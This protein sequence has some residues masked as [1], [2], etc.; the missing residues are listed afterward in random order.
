MAW[1]F[2][3]NADT[4]AVNWVEVGLTYGVLAAVI[5]VS[6]IALAIVK[7]CEEGSNPF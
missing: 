1:I 4:G 5:L 3:L 7:T 6:L 2:M